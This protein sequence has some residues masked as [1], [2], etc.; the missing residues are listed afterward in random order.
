MSFSKTVAPES[1]PPVHCSGLLV[2]TLCA[3]LSE[4]SF[5]STGN[6]V[7]AVS[8]RLP[9]FCSCQYQL[10]PVWVVCF[11][12]VLFCFLT[13]TTPFMISE[14]MDTKQL[15]RMHKHQGDPLRQWLEHQVMKTSLEEQR[16]SARVKEHKPNVDFWELWLNLWI[17]VS[18]LVGRSWQ[19]HNMRSQKS[20]AFT[21]LRRP[22]FWVSQY[23]IFFFFGFQF[24]EKKKRN[25]LH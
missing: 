5:A 1:S 6:S 2:S 3:F 18:S 15:F 13:S 7:T 24:L 14:A 19:D 17:T 9:F 4:E 10:S 22:I 16:V 11:V 20:S 25:L 12:F 23:L 8:S 21:S